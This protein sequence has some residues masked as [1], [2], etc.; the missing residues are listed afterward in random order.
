MALEAIDQWIDAS[1]TPPDQAR[2][3]GFL[4]LANYI[5]GHIDSAIESGREDVKLKE[6]A[7]LSAAIAKTNLAYYLA[8]KI[9]ISSP[10]SENN[11]L[12]GEINKFRADTL[13]A[14]KSEKNI[15][16]LA[17]YKDSWGAIAIMTATSIADVNGG[18][19][20]CNDARNLVKGTEGE[21]VFEAYYE[22][23][24]RRAKNKLIELAR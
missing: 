7:H 5:L 2:A 11:A 17:S 18:L 4:A 23:H 3:R 12:L 9:Y 24:D 19:Q 20:S 22:L 15:Q 13:K 8:E 6:E 10:G 14:Q 1:T 21:K 16:L